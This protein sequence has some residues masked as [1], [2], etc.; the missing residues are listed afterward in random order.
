MNNRMKYYR[1]KKGLTQQVMAQKLGV[2]VSTYNMLENG[3]RG[4]SLPI[5][6]NISLLLDST[7]DAIFFDNIV[8][9]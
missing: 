2:A 3:K 8:H 7:I 1:E 6:K 4:I 9:R 5:A